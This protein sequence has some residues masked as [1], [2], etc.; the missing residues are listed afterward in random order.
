MITRT[1]PAW[2]TEDWQ[3][4]LSGLITSVDELWALLEL[5]ADGLEAAREAATQFP[6]KVPRGFVAKMER[7]NPS[8]PLLRQ[9]L[10]HGDE[11][12]EVAGYVTDPLDEAAANPL[13]GVLHKYESRVLV[14]AGSACAVHCRYCFRRHF[15]YEDNG[16]PQSRL[17]Q[18]A[19]YL[20]AHPEV[21]EVIFSGGDP[22]VAS[23]QRIRQWL[24]R[25]G[26]V[27]GL[28]RIRFHSRTPVV[29]PERLDEGLLEAFSASGLPVI[30]VLHANHPREI[31]QRL[32][33]ALAP[34][35]TAGITL[36]NQSVLLAGV[37]DDARVLADLSEA[38]FAAGVLPYYLH[39]PDRVAGAAHF[40]RGDTVAT[41]IYRE[42][43]TL[44]PGFLLP[45]L[46]REIPGE[47]AKRLI[48]PAF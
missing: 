27:P 35:R 14:V 2:H 4:Q 28:R 15:P 31:D 48:L 24:A 38:L 45:R 36:L 12:R 23:N 5:P 26:Q 8:D 6:L 41:A 13:A 30:L 25:L 3:R 1:A 44:L 7:G 29:I 40:D 33:D 16:F 39:V 11:L 34:F 47:P 20:D 17:E 43:T 42:L 19:D 22:L 10:A 32:I 37:N 46:A 21:N 9:V 18:L